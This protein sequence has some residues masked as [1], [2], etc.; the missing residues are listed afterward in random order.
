MTRIDTN[1]IIRYLLDDNEEMATIAEEVIMYKNV[2][3][4]NE[5]LAEVVYV[6]EDVYDYSR[7][8]ISSV[9]LELIEFDNIETSDKSIVL[10][11]FKLYAKKNLDS[12]DC[13]LCAYA[14]IDEVLT[15]DKKLMKC[16][17]GE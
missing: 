10:N 9:L 4:S 14:K 16:V 13:L 6:L 1:Y 15:F 17:G 2:Y 11:A 7:E 3:I 12:V 8:K 5:V